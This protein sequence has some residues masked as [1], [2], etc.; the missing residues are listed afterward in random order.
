M[1]LSVPKC[2]AVTANQKTVDAVKF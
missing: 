2:R 1:A